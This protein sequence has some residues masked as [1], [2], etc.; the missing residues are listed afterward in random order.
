MGVLSF[1]ASIRG[2]FRAVDFSGTGDGPWATA[3]AIV[4]KNGND[5]LVGADGSLTV[6][7]GFSYNHIAANGTVNV[8]ASPGTLHGLTINTKGAT[9]N[10]ATVYDSLAGSGAVIAIIDTTANVGQV[11]LDVAFTIGLTVVVGTGTAADIT[12]AYK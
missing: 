2:G 3:H 8:K 4:D 10:I 12:V 11:I 9:G 1:F 6:G 7:G 5:L